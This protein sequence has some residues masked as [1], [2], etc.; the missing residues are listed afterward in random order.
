[1]LEAL[2]LGAQ[3]LVLAVN[4]LAGATEGLELA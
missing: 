1:M 4:E 3:D 2:V